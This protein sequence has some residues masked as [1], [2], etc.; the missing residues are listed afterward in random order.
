MEIVM[1]HFT[2]LSV[3]FAAA[4]AVPTAQA[5][6]EFG[7]ANPDRPSGNIQMLYKT[8]PAMQCYLSARDGVELKAG[9]AYCNTAMR[10]PMMNYRAKIFVNR[11]II[12]HDLGD[13]KGAL[14]DFGNSIEQDPA[15]GDTYL[16]QALVLVDEKRP[17]EAL[18]AI[19]KGIALGAPS[20]HLAY[21][22]RGAAEDDAGNYNEAYRDYKQALVVK[23]DYEP[24]KRQLARFKV[25][26]GA[27]AQEKPPVPTGGG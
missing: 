4:V 14:V 8:N 27:Q 6:G 1:K 21:Y 19:S 10:D 20:L 22:A 25:T 24:A 17:M 2:L 5:T 11:A 15:S 12:R 7:V 18:A 3:L 23:P 13:N 26:N 16:N 9:L